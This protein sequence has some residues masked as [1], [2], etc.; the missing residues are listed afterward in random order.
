MKGMEASRRVPTR[1]S[2]VDAIRPQVEGLEPYHPIVPLDVLAAKLGRDPSTIVKLDANEN[3]Y[4]PSPQVRHALANIDS[5]HIYPDSENLILRT[6][7]ADYSRAPAENLFAGA[8]S[9]ELIDL[10]MRLFVETGDRIIDCP[11]TFGMY[12]FDAAVNGARVICVARHADFSLDVPAIETA[13]AEH[14]PKLLF[15]SSPNNPDGSLVCES[16]LCRLLDLPVVV[17]LDEAYIEFATAGTSRL[18]WAL[19][20]PNLIVLRTFSKWAG[21]AGLRVG[22]GAF[23]LELLTHLWKIK[24]PYN[25][26][27][28]A[29]AAAIASLRDREYLNDVVA[30]IVQE[31]ERLYGCLD[32]TPYLCPYMSQANFVLCRVHGRSARDLQQTLAGEGILVRYFDKPGL[33]DHIRV[34]VGRPE[35]TDA[36]V[37]VLKQLD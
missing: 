31:R 36:L 10:I 7:L 21:L 5:P 6:E 23:P 17:V 32:E 20:Y 30:R 28:A 19:K 3:V 24:Q 34:S 22:Y 4:G 13:V 2:V 12:S 14:S 37:R 29:T 35:N 9:D 1:Q 26:S 8:G 15:L 33:Q 16:D 18:L 27:V 25:V 11:P